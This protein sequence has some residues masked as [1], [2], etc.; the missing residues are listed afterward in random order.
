MVYTRSRLFLTNSLPSTVHVCEINFFV[1]SWRTLHTRLLLFVRSSL[2][3]TSATYS[4]S[5]RLLLELRILR[6]VVLSR[7]RTIIYLGF[8]E[9]FLGLYNL[10]TRWE[11]IISPLCRSLSTDYYVLHNVCCVLA[12]CL[13][14]TTKSDELS[15]SILFKDF[16]LVRCCMQR[17]LHRLCRRWMILLCIVTSDMYLWA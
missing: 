9:P 5:F 7:R 13:Y 16:D 2:M 12:G 8:G 6:L 11:R 15:V 3:L 14:N 10:P 17:V 4:L 1:F